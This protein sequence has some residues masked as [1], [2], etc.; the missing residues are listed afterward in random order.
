MK[1]TRKGYGRLLRPDGSQISQH[2]V[3]E[4]AYERAAAEGPGRYTYQPPTIQIDVPGA[5]TTPAPSPVPAPEPGPEPPPGSPEPSPAPVEPEPAPAEPVEPPAGAGFPLGDL[6]HDGPATPEQIAL[7]LPI[8]GEL[9]LAAVAAV[10]YHDGIAWRQ[11]HPLVR[12][13][14]EFAPSSNPHPEPA[15]AGM[16]FDLQPGATYRIEV[17]VRLGDL[18]ATRSLTWTTRALP[19]A[20]G[21]AT[22]TIPAGSTTAQIA[23]LIKAAK[24]GDVIEF[25]PGRYELNELQITCKGTAQQPIYIR[26]RSRDAVVL[27]DPNGRVVHFVG[28]THCVLEDLTIEGSGQDSGT[29]AGSSGVWI[30]NGARHECITVRRLT[31]RGVDRGVIAW[32]EGSQLLVYDNVLEGNNGWEK[33]TL[34]SNASWNDDGIMAAGSG[35]AVFNNTLSGFGDAFC[36]NAGY[37]NIGVHF[38]RN[39]V[40]WTC[41]DGCEA[42]YGARNL[43]FYDNR[44][45]NAM[46]MLSCD[47]LRIGPLFAFRNVAINIG[48]QPFKL[49]STMTGLFLYSNTIV[50]QLGMDTYAGTY[51]PGSSGAV[52]HRAWGYRNNLFICPTPALANTLWWET[53]GNDPIDCDHNA[54]WP[55]ARFRWNFS[56]GNF[57]SL[58]LAQAGLRATQP[59]FSGQTQR[60]AHD[61]ICEPQPFR[62]PVTLGT[63]YDVRVDGEHAVVPADD[64]AVRGAGVA[65]PGITDGYAGGAPDIGAVI[66]GR[67]APVVGARR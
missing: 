54:W 29:A 25:A 14:P 19:A 61:I 11:A 18:A 23:A 53:S 58:A 27:S 44:I 50:R 9:D 17:E 63:T 6:Q 42:D 45:A 52:R 20:A 8:T 65:I 1:F 66:T 26:G 34:E 43:S 56:G 38:Y 46:T 37:S 51:Q 67:P 12:Q 7:Y 59:V 2:T 39:R 13:R 62:E 55:N 32:G 10:R 28:A 60:H 24:P 48:R 35:N 4:E 5:V 36:V 41:D 22:I 40:L 31:I 3:A 47:P 15:F 30:W 49:N 33:A 57:D 16:I 21:P 64:S